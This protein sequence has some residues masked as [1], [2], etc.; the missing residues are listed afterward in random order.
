[1]LENGPGIPFPIELEPQT[2][3]RRVPRHHLLGVLHG[4]EPPLSL[5]V[6]HL[7]LVPVF[8]ALP[9]R[10]H[11]P[12]YPPLLS[13]QSERHSLRRNRQGIHHLEASCPLA[14]R[15][16]GPE[17]LVA[18]VVRQS[19]TAAIDCTE[20]EFFLAACS[21]RRGK[22]CCRHGFRRHILALKQPVCALPFSIV[23]VHACD[24][25]TRRARRPSCHGDQSRFPSTVLKLSIAKYL[26]C[27]RL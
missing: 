18:L 1:M 14:T 2:C 12:S 22:H 20:H 23:S 19:Q 11:V 13:R 15:T 24:S 21:G 9:N 8:L 17:P 6:A 4:I 26:S 5:L 25:A 10:D 16:D 27:P 3:L 7:A